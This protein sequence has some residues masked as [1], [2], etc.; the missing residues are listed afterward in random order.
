MTLI[1]TIVIS[2]KGFKQIEFW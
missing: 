1:L 2:S